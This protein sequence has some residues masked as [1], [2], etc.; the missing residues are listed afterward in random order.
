M[1]D[2]ILQL[3]KTEHVYCVEVTAFGNV[4]DALFGTEVVYRR[5]D[6]ELGTT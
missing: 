5:L 4:Y 3:P 2:I 6:F 1:R